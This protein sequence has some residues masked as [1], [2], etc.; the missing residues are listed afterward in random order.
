MIILPLGLYLWSKCQETSNIWWH[1]LKHNTD[2]YT[3]HS[4]KHLCVSGVI[5]TLEFIP[6]EE[7]FSNKCLLLWSSSNILPHISGCTFTSLAK[8]HLHN[9][10]VSQSG[11]IT[12]VLVVAGHLSENSPHDLPFMDN[13]RRKWRSCYH[14]EE[15][16]VGLK[17]CCVCYL[18]GFSGVREHSE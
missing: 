1:L 8:K 14:V 18:S 9:L 17:T 2:I 15:V 12:Q 10:W 13:R 16:H 3:K 11:K 7:E 6:H 4:F 5:P